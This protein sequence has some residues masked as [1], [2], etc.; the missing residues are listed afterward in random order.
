MVSRKASAS[1]PFLPVE[2]L[3]V[4]IDK[5]DACTIVLSMWFRLDVNLRAISS[6]SVIALTVSNDEMMTLVL[7]LLCILKTRGDFCLPASPSRSRCPARSHG[8][9]RW[10]WSPT[11][12]QWTKFEYSCPTHLLRGET[13]AG[14]WYFSRTICEICTLPIC[15]SYHTHIIDSNMITISRFDVEARSSTM[16]RQSELNR[17]FHLSSF[18]FVIIDPVQRWTIISQSQSESVGDWRWRMI[19]KTL[20]CADV[21]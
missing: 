5:L 12:C 1:L 7:R 3:H 11:H 20:I 18:S 13:M 16:S 9:P 10:R 21:S 8:W 15:R 19:R 6:E 14:N 2:T 17:K 4:I